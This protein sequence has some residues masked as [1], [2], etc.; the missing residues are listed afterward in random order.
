MHAI[1]D[2]GFPYCTPIQAQVLGYTLAGRDAIGRAQTGTGKTAAFLISTITQLL[3]TPPPRTHRTSD[4]RAPHP[5]THDAGTPPAARP[6]PYRHPPSR[7]SPSSRG[8][9]HAPS[10]L[11]ENP[12]PRRRQTVDRKG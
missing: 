5:R 3:D 7:G 9:W 4:A 1:H 10:R 12:P 11:G 2:L 6:E 8:R